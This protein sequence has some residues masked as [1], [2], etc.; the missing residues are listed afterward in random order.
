VQVSLIPAPS[1]KEKPEMFISLG[2][3][4]QEVRSQA[5]PYLMLI[6]E[7]CALKKR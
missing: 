2:K 5:D 3:D 4:A 1:F 6:D 7:Q